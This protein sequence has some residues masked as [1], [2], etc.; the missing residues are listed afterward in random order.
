[1]AAL[2]A[3]VAGAG[4]VEPVCLMASTPLIVRAATLPHTQA[5]GDILPGNAF[6]SLM[7]FEEIQPYHMVIF[8]KSLKISKKN[9][10]H[11]F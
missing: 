2:E 11:V 1:M 5:G 10:F 4:S 3:V 7:P 9:Q 8:K 6:V